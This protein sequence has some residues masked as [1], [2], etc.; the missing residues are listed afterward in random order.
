MRLLLTL[1]LFWLPISEAQ[2]IIVVKKPAAGA[3]ITY[4]GIEGTGSASGPSSVAA[5]A[6]NTAVGDLVICGVKWESGSS[7]IIAADTAGNTYS[8]R[9]AANNAGSSGEPH[10]RIFYTF[11][12]AANASNVVTVTFSG[13]TTWSKII[14]HEFTGATSYDAEST[15]GEAASGT[16][17][18]TGAIT[19]T[20]GAVVWSIVGGYT[21]QTFSSP[22]IGGGA[23]TQGSTVSDSVAHW[24]IFTGAQS[25]I[26]ANITQS[27]SDRW[28]TTAAAFK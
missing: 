27:A 11:A 22:L 16:A 18:A 4:K 13:S 28:T 19:T 9:T 3:T 12:T 7:A 17:V 23:S 8:A 21:A 6:M 5:S 15:A 26:T 24:R 10:V 14:C 1:L 25:S 2:T 20:A